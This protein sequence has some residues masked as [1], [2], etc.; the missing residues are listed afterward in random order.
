MN[1][2]KS[3]N[4]TVKS[5]GVCEQ[6]VYDLEVED[7]HNFFANNI[8]IHN[9]LYLSLGDLAEKF[10]KSKPDINDQQMTD[11]IDKFTEE[12]IQPFIDKTYEKLRDYLNGYE[13]SL[14]MKREKIAKSIIFVQKKRYTM[15]VID[16]EGVR[17]HD[18]KISTTGL[19]SVRSTTPEVIRKKLHEF[20]R[21]LLLEDEE[22]AHNFLT[23]MKKDFKNYKIEEIAMVK[24]VND[25]EKWVNSDRSVVKSGTPLQVKA[26]TLYNKI[27]LEHDPHT[28]I[29][30]SGDKIHLVNIKKSMKFL[31]ETC[32]AYPQVIP[33]ELGLTRE[34][35]DWNMMYEKVFLSAAQILM[36]AM[37]MEARKRSAV[38]LA[39]F[40]S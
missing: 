19:E 32:I 1:L 13:Q 23:A 18:L 20:E 35:V 31:N 15:A 17:Y 7:N 5:L 11:L 22:A 14:K 33:P 25:I 10:S 26:A 2:K 36:G 38:S 6:D 27:M 12:K 8:C 4:F 21:I 9:S 16:N 37:G 29:I 40:F 24:S 34:I 30:A 39:N 3:S 28:S